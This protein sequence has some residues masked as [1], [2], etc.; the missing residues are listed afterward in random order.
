MGIEDKKLKQWE[1]LV[2]A[3]E[4]YSQCLNL[5]VA[6]LRG[7]FQLW[8]QKWEKSEN[9]PHSALEALDY[10]CEYYPNISTL[11]QL[12]ATLPVSTAEAERFFSS[13]ERTL[14]T[15]RASMSESRLQD[16]LLLH[17]NRKHTPSIDQVIDKF[18]ETSA[19][20]LKF[21]L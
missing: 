8:H 6:E 12:L 1:L 15:I 10:C 19:R 11:L 2:A 20:R 9:R 5:S 16:L 7:E 18:A 3:V 17:V 4:S 14:T 21:L 13:M